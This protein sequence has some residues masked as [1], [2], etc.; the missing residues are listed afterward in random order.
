MK[1]IY[2]TLLV[3]ITL[4]SCSEDFLDNE[5]K[6]Y[7]SLEQIQELAQSSPESFLNVG[8][9]LDVGSNAYLKDWNS[10]GNG[11]HDD[12]GQ[13]SIDLGLDLMGND[14][15]QVTYH[16]FGMYYRYDGRTQTNRLTEMVW[17]FYYNVIRNANEI[18]DFIPEDVT[19]PTVLQIKGRALALRAYGYFNLLRIY[20]QYDAA[21]S[22]P[23]LPIYTTAS[24]IEG[25]PRVTV[26]E[27]K[28]LIVSD[29]DDAYQLLDGFSRT[30]KEQ[31][32]QHVVS[33]LRARYNLTYGSLT[34]AITEAQNA[35][36]SSTLGDILDGFDEITNSGWIWGGDINNE[37]STVYASF[38]SHMA[39]DNPGYAGLLGIYK[40]VDKRLYESI[41]DTDTRKQWFYSTY[42]N[43]KFKDDTF[44]EGDYLYMRAAEMYLI[45]AE[46]KALS[47]DDTGAAQVLF[48]L[49]S[50]RDASY[51][52]S[53]NTGQA[54]LDEIRL[55]R[56]IELWGEGFS[57]YD[58]KRWQRDLVRDY[59]DSNHAGY[60]LVNIA[61]GS[62]E[63][64][65]QIPDDELN[66]N[67]HI[68]PGD[69][70]P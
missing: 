19:D 35:R 2:L 22:D 24:S 9:A 18:I 61:A 52:L 40:S 57:W 33:G 29:L 36:S 16:W 34:T 27:V 39:T 60:G 10:L 68:G 4:A 67:P 66:T 55:Q 1:K 48:D 62:V 50:T 64:A 13:K 59:P 17:N 42:Q 70:N 6:E 12:F 63:N 20:T 44:F 58:L 37:S 65:F 14:V 26:G 5:N 7:V 21:D 30:N 51:T 11:S 28:S 49:V 23:G 3:A 41:P 43:R 53:T 45:E 8:N 32:D 69:Q 15:I 31:I 54:L 47:G 56:S 46:A 38:F 25:Q